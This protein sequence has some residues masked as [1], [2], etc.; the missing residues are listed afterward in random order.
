MS[1]MRTLATLAIGF[2]AARG[3]DKFRKAGG[4]PGMQDMLR[5]AGAPGGIADRMGEMAE[6]IGLPGGREGVRKMVDQ[7]GDQAA[8]AT[9]AAEAGMGSLLG[10]AKGAVAAGTGAL[11]S[12]LDAM[13]GGAAATA[14][15]EETAK[16]MI[17][18]MIQGAKADG[19][20]DAEEQA[21]IMD[22]L[23]DAT[24]EEIAFV[25]AELAAPVDL[26]ALVAATGGALKAQVYGAAL[27]VAKGDSPA[28][29]AF[30]AQLAQGLELSRDIRAA[31]HSAA[32]IAP[33]EA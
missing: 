20:V 29:R 7:M 26:A 23:K 32:G 6:K 19:E 1:F 25:K 30:L 27:T 16:L 24:P 31:I 22:H 14:T 21:V 4:M 13:P 18:A 11:G 12:T 28:E 15:A 8:R 2:A 9:G 10:T 5:N 33:P 3:V 17:R